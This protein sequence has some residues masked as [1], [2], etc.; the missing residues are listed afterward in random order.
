MIKILLIEDDERLR[1]NIVEILELYGYIVYTAVDGQEGYEK[2]LHLKPDLIICDLNMPIMNG[3]EFITKIK[4]SALAQTPILLL[5][6]TRYFDNHQKRAIAEASGF[7]RKP[8]LIND[9][10]LLIKKY[11]GNY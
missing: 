2:T 11:T 9:L 3:P 8:F 6:G 4:T 5:T 1:Q 10:I 7:L